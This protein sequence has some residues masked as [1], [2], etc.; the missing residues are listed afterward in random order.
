MT[1]DDGAVSFDTLFPGHYVGR[2]THIHVMVHTDA[3]AH[4]NGTVHSTTAS[5]VGQVYFDQSLITTMERH[6][7][8][9][10]NTQPLT[11]NEQ[12]FLLR[13][14]AQT[15]DPFVNYVYMGDEW[16]DG[17]LGWISFGVNRTLA[18]QI[19]PGAILYEE[20]G[21]AGPGGGFPGG[22]PPGF[23]TG[24]FPFPTQT[25]AP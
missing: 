9:V 7:A 21:E 25:R 8:Y 14:A 4:P 18:R 1:D 19:N 16:T 5:H 13:Q 10:P 2:T 12:D 20:G 6:S 24:G 23:P 17:V 11:T 15:S 3:Q 22:P